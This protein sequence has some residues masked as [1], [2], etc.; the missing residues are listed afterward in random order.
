M[1]SAFLKPIA[2]LAVSLLLGAPLGANAVTFN[3]VYDNLGGNN[4]I[5]TVIGKGTF[6]Y[7]GPLTFGAF[8]LN[9]LTGVTFN[10]SFNNGDTFTLA[11]LTNNTSQDGI[12]VFSLGGGNAGLV[13]TGS[14][15]KAGGSFDLF[16]ASG[17]SLSHEPTSAINNPLGCCGGNGIINEYIESG[18]ALNGLGD[19]QA[20]LQ[21]TVP[22]PAPLA[23]IG[24]GFAGIALAR[25]RA[26]P[27]SRSS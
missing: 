4:V 6:S 18:G 23:L 12:D 20:T 24:I 8:A 16:D 7:S 1:R 13:F 10:A 17:I 26:V 5:D 27:Q 21:Q 22:E 15:G 9:T 25:R 2:A 19:Y 14:G 3:I 11:N